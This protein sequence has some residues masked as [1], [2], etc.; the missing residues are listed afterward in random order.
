[1]PD[2]NRMTIVAASDVVFTFNTHND[3]EPGAMGSLGSLQCLEQD[4]AGRST[5]Q[6]RHR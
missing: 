2:F 3:I 1:M 5:C 6:D 4:G